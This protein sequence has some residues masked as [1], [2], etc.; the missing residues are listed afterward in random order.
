MCSV[1]TDFS[2]SLFIVQSFKAC[3]C[4]Y[5]NMSQQLHILDTY[6]IA[7]RYF[8]EVQYSTQNQNV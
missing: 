5:V 3:L 6:N 7:L 8:K 4:N 1:Y 2:E